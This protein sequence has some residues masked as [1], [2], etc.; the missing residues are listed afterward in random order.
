MN[1]ATLQTEIA[2]FLAAG[3]HDAVFRNWPG[4]HVLD[5]VRAG[6]Q[7]MRDALV[8]ELSRRESRVTVC[9]PPALKSL[10]LTAFA[11]GKVEPMVNGLFPVEERG[12]VLECLEQSLCFLTPD[13]VEEAIR[14]T[15]FLHTARTVANMYLNSI[16]AD[17]LGEGQVDAV[18]FSVET[19]CYVSMAY[20]ESSDPL[21]DYVVHEAA[22][23]FHNTPREVLG[24]PVRRSREWLL[25]I[26]YHKRETFAYGCEFYSR[27]L[28]HGKSRAERRALL[29]S[30]ESVPDERV[31]IEELREVLE[32]AVR[33]RNGWSVI[34]ENCS[35]GS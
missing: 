26:D 2:D 30:I 5:R 12:T 7:A 35:T 27:L 23:V 21:E 18:G 13:T 1:D 34:L 28:E 11:R 15:R 20:F 33:A 19:S 31:D 6:D 10:D 32:G 9:L 24:L 4:R 16:G 25:P 14:R 17:L 3:D 8:A 29:A 22:H